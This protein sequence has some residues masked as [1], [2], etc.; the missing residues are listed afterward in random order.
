MPGN[1]SITVTK[2]SDGEIRVGITAI[3]DPI[4][5]STKV[6]SIIRISVQK[7]A[8]KT[9]HVFLRSVPMPESF[10]LLGAVG[11]GGVPPVSAMPAGSME[12]AVGRSSSEMPLKSSLSSLI[13]ISYCINEL[14][15]WS[16][17]FKSL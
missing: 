15:L 7:R 11:G 13:V 10:S 2:T 17:W 12:G 3:D 16:Y 5:I 4:T 1:I 9:P 6:S 14:G 8:L